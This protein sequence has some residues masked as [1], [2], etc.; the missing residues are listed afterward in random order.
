MAD[1]I[2]EIKVQPRASKNE[3]QG[4]RGNVL[5]ART[6][7][8]PVDSEANSALLKML[9]KVLDVPKTNITIITGIRTRHKIVKIIG[10]EREEVIKRLTPEEEEK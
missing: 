5:W 2:I 6:T 4:F 10:M 3:L 7:A 1:T 8:A 9:S